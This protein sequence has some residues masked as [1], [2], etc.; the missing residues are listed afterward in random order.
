MS[1]TQAPSRSSDRL[2]PVLAHGHGE[3]FSSDGS[4][5]MADA[6]YRSR[7]TT[8]I[9]RKPPPRP[10][11]RSSLAPDAAAVRII[12]ALVGA[13]VDTFFGIPGGPSAPLFEALRIVPG[14]RLI[15][16]RHESSAA[17][18]AA[19]FQ[20][21]TGR[22]PALLLTA[23]P[24]LTNALTG[25]VSAHLERVPMLVISGD[26]AWASRGAR[27]AQDSGP[28]GIAAEQIYAACTRATLRVARPA[29]AATQALAA[30]Q[31]AVDPLT[32]GPALLIVPI[33]RAFASAPPVL[34][35]AP[36]L[37]VTLPAAEVD[38]LHAAR[39]LAQARR[40]LLVLGG[41]TRAHAGVI[42]HLVDVLN[43]PFVTTPRA[44][45][46]VSETHPRSLRN[47]GMAA[48]LWARRYTAEPIDVAL[49]LGTDL[50]DS[51]MGPTPYLGA[52]GALIHVDI[53]PNVFRRNL[54]TALPVIADLGD[55]AQKLYDMVLAH[56]LHHPDGKNLMRAVRSAP[57]FDAPGYATDDGFPIA[58]H[59]AI[60]DLEHAAGPNA[61]FISDIGEHMLFAL[62]YLTARDPEAFHIQLN[63]G[64]MGSGIAGAIGLAVADR[65]RRV[66][67]I[68]GD[69]GMQ[70]SGMELL[71]AQRERL[72][73]VYAVFND[74]RYNMVHHG[75]KQ[76]FGSA[77]AWDSPPV[78]FRAWAGS[79]GVPSAIIDSPGQIDA[80]LI[81]RLLDHGGPGVLDIRIDRELRIR[82]GGRVEAL[83]H[84]SMLQSGAGE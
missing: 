4:G 39:M 60:A 1:R 51:S 53:D 21:A 58:P 5:V 29:S 35:R 62:H 67:C 26:V 32:P 48:S 42:R 3:A 16:S 80:V 71:V 65:S 70:M 50:D 31:A 30:L 59:R 23:G 47:G 36:A 69:G 40:P 68:C 45:G 6:P 33:D 44:K 61:R 38:V 14:A 9:V 75:M 10:E 27:L 17:F 25:V 66:V 74:G 41:A 22:V 15:E 19:T 49:A 8:G 2:E 46:V 28:E 11:V 78:D 43:V 18:A 13:G 84:M 81:D 55:F 76:I 56:G 12:E 63:L 7:H 83:Q 24:G 54:P 77:N 34:T 37:H 72:P 73:I 79:F 64:S 57:A 20:R 82:G 52:D